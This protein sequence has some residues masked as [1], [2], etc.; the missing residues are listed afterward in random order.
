TTYTLSLHAA[1]PIWSRALAQ[2]L[3]LVSL[4]LDAKPLFDVELPYPLLHTNVF[5]RIPHLIAETDFLR[6]RV[7]QNKRRRNIGGIDLDVF[8]TEGALPKRLACFQVFHP[9]KLKRI[10]HFVENAFRHFQSL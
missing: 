5:D 9:I 3:E 8:D 10:G 2:S 7:N 4:H 1:L 6:H